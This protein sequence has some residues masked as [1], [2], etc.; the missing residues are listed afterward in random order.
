[1]S[2]WHNVFLPPDKMTLMHI[3]TNVKFDF[4]YA[5]YIS[6]GLQML[7]INTNSLKKS[8]DKD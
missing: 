3:F 4:F 2:N 5:K 6:A 8:T 1:M 7:I